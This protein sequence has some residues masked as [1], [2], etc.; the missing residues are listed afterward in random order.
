MSKAKEY[1]VLIVDDSPLNVMHLSNILETEYL[2]HTANSGPMAIE[3]A[4]K[5]MPDVILLD[6][7]MPKMDGYAT[8]EELKKSGITKDIP[9]IFITGLRNERDEEKGLSLGAADYITKPFSPTIVKLRV[10]NQIKI[11]ESLEEARQANKDKN[12]LLLAMSKNAKD[13]NNKAG[14]ILIVDDEQANIITL[15]YILGTDYKIH[16]AKNGKDAIEITKETIPDI[17]LLDILMPEMDGYAT[18]AELKKTE[19]TKDI[20]VIFITSKTD[21]ESEIKGLNLGAVDYI[22]KPFSHDLLLK[23]VDLHLKLKQYSSGLET[24]VA[25][26]TLVVNEL[27]NA[28][29]ETFSECVDSRDNITGGHIDRTQSYLGLLVKL[30]LDNS[31]YARELS[32]WDVDLF[33]TSSQ[34]HDVGKI[35]IS[36]NILNKPGKL[37]DEEFDTMK[38]HAEYGREIITKIEKRT[39]AN[40]FLEHAE[41][42]A[43]DHHEKWNGT[44]YPRGLSK[45]EIPLQGRLMAIVDVY[46]ALTND[47]P[48]KKAFTHEKAMDIIREGLGTHFDPVICETFIKHNKEFETIKITLKNEDES[49]Q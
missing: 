26:K 46:D 9:V 31:E 43:G 35:S 21:P 15:E 12:D 2:L 6:V 38:K 33:I 32:T 11:L 23:R 22:I 7:L 48:Y 5:K 49:E 28:V 13:D 39:S 3:E 30:L 41:K 14:S 45:E 19:Q 40:S 37:T 17:I 4:A 36:D 42:L 18:I 1:S 29:L 8:I 16:V 27:Q 24:I 20:P 10:K 34:L 44:G 47:R 25:Q